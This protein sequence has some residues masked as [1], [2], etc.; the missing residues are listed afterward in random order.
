MPEVEVVIAE[1][2]ESVKS[3]KSE[4]GDWTLNIIKDG[5]NTDFSV[6]T[7]A[8]DAIWALAKNSVGK[9]MR[10]TYDEKNGKKNVTELAGPLGDD[11]GNGAGPT[12]GTGEYIRGK[13]ASEDQ[14]A[15]NARKALDLAVAFMPTAEAKVS[16]QNTLLAADFFFEWLEEKCTGSQT[17][18]TPPPDDPDD[19]PF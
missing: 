5:N 8:K 13:T 6:F 7:P 2:K 10:V 9:R 19:I 14:I 16:T 11:A 4:Y 12:P 18:P 15:I 3:G 17:G 1:V